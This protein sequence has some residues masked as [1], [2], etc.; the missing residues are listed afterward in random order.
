MI[1][2]PDGK[3][4]VK[5]SY[6]TYGISAVS[7]WNINNNATIVKKALAEYFT[8]GTPIEETIGNCNDIMEFQFI[9][10][11]GV[12]YREAYHIVDGEKSTGSEGKS[13]VCE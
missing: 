5:G 3:T 2:Y 9:A 12:K 11:A 10:K 4:K 6:L 1:V 7:A 8:K 13:S